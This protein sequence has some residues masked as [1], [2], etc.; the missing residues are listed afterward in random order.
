MESNKLA[1]SRG[2]GLGL[3]IPGAICWLVSG[4]VLADA[5]HAGASLATRPFL[6]G[7]IV[8]APL[9]GCGLWLLLR[10]PDRK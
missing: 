6:C 1:A 4:M 2:I 9:I 5:F 10:T 7:L 8:G 3:L